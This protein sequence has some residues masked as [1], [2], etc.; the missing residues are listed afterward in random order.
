MRRISGIFGKSSA[1][2]T[3]LE[4]ASVKT[5]KPQSTHTISLRV[6]DE[7]K[8]RLERD[9]AGM[10]RSAYIRERLFGGAA[11]PR[12]TRGKYPVKDFEALGRV[13]GLL[14]RSG[15]YNSMHRLVLAI[16]EDRFAVDDDIVSEIRK[17]HATIAAM[18][19]DLVLALGL[20]PENPQ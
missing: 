17:T 3:E 10:A 15:I 4:S 18:R 7:E 8:A 5:T 20:K 2:A 13:L 9:A 12:K 1:I 6:T 16:E 14:G 19:R 11:R